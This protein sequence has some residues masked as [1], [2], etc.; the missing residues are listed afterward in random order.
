MASPTMSD[1]FDY[2]EEME[3]KV[4][5]LEEQT[6]KNISKTLSAIETAIE[7]WNAAGKQP[8]SLQ[9]K[10]SRLK[11]FYNELMIWEKKSIQKKGTKDLSGRVK[12]LN[13]FIE[14]CS[15]QEQ[16]IARG[17]S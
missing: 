2:P 17:D 8:P 15:K 3:E 4:S 13:Q 5:T 12:R 16:I 14:I 11:N 7:S 1:S 9:S 10:I 6:E